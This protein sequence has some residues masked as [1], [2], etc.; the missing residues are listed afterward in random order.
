MTEIK[1][2][3]LD[4]DGTLLNSQDHVSEKT[5]SAIVEA[6][7]K[8]VDVMIATGRSLPA[9][10]DHAKSLGLNEYIITGNGSEIWLFPGPELVDRR[11]LKTDLVEVMWELKQTYN[12]R[13]WAASTSK[14]WKREM[15]ENI[16][17]EEWLKFGYDLD[18]FQVREAIL[19]ELNRYD[20]LEISNSHPLNIEVNAAGV[21]K[22]NA[23]EQ[24]LKRKNLDIAQVMACGDSLNDIKMIQRAGAGIAMGNAQDEVKEHADF[25]T[26]TNDEDGIVQAFKQYG[27]IS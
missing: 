15:P 10:E 16:G 9:A 22:A 4:M 7:R 12:A 8:G 26:G 21:H 3:V 24:V 18:D 13:H 25:I 2:A 19:K 11:P 6:S 23:I 27:V 20:G 5:R 1:L 14:V 17:S